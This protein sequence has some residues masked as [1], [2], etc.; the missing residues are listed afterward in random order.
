MSLVITTRTIDRFTG[1][2]GRRRCRCRCAARRRRSDHRAGGGARSRWIGPIVDQ[3]GRN[4][5]DFAQFRRGRTGLNARLGGHFADFFRGILLFD[6]VQKVQF[7]R[8]VVLLDRPR[9]RMFDRTARM[10]RTFALFD[11]AFAFRSRQPIDR[12]RARRRNLRRL[13]GA[14]LVVVVVHFVRLE[15][16]G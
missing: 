2:L 10:R 4:L 3:R 15:L 7:R 5:F 6:R 13:I 16:F 12:F 11:F 9:I 1:R 14:E 8:R